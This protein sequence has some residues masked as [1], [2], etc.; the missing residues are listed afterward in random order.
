MVCG[1]IPPRTLSPDGYDVS[2]SDTYGLHTRGQLRSERTKGR[3]YL[4]MDVWYLD[5]TNLLHFS[6]HTFEHTHACMASKGDGLF[7][8]MKLVD[9]LCLLKIFRYCQ[10][11]KT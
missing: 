10:I 2:C 5:T 4:E 8:I 9:V 3:A 1:W 11:S 7:D 6:I